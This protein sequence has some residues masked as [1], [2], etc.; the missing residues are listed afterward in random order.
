MTQ[1]RSSRSARSSL[2]VLWLLAAL[3]LITSACGVRPGE[4]ASGA[5]AADLVHVH[6][7]A[8]APEGGLYVATHTGL[9]QV[10]GDQI[11]AVGGATHDLMGF[12]V[13]GP[14]DLL[15]SGHP[16]LRDQSLQVAGKPPLLGL[17][18][19]DDGTTWEPLSLLGDVDFHN[20]V[21]AHGRVYGSD[22][23]SG[24][25]MVSEDRETWDTRAERLALYD[26]AVSPDDPDTIVGSGEAGLARSRDGGRT[27]EAVSGEPHVFLSWADEGLYGVTSQ[28][29]VAVSGDAG[30]TWDQRGTVEGPPEALLVTGEAVYVAVAEVGIARSDDRGENFQVT[31]PTAAG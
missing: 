20:L 21:A 1:R 17:V 18:H 23:T 3:A 6:G 25:F 12:T 7:L 29:Q 8:E 13:A 16:D 5:T 2:G 10:N 27:W 4:A 15:A 19:S 9:F 14:G 11:E 26:F 31:I 22:S 24:A 30:A 28:G